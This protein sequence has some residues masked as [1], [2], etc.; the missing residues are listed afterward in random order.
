V[1][2]GPPILTAGEV[3]GVIDRTIDKSD[4]GFL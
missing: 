1:H 4:G 2:L 3:V